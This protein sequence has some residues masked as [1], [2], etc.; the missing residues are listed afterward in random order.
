MSS[1]IALAAVPG[2]CIVAMMLIAAI[3]GRRL[4][5][6]KGKIIFPARPRK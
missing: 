3:S 4:E 6:S 1:L 2:A 5:I